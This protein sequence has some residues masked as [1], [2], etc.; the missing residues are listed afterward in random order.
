MEGLLQKKSQ[1][2]WNGLIG[3]TKNSVI[4][5][6]NDFNAS[7]GQTVRFDFSGA[8]VN[9]GFRGKEQAFGKGKDK[10]KFSDSITL[11]YGRYTV[12]NGMKFDA[13][14]IGDIA[15]STHENS[16]GLLADA[17]VRSK[18][19]MFFD[20][21]QGYLRG[22]APTHIIRSA[23]IGSMTAADKI[24]WDYIVDLELKVKTGMGMAGGRRVALE[25]VTTANGQKLW[26]LVLDSWQIADLLLDPKFQAIYQNAQVRGQNNELLSHVIAKIGNIMI[27]EAQ[28]FA[29][30]VENNKLFKQAV[31]TQGLRTIDENGVFSGTG[32]AQSGNVAS[33]GLLLGAGAFLYANGEMPNYLFQPSPDFGI[34]SESCLELTM[35]VEKTNLTAEVEDY[36]DAKIADMDY[37]I[38]AVDTYNE[39]LSA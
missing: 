38:I 2:F 33:R 3:N 14:T 21:G 22:E 9:T 25:P 32:T 10:L 29:G 1:S 18:D 30:W 4:Y 8:Y 24:S 34:T 19:Q 6:K 13:A 7:D 11:E 31:Q 5:Q 37:G 23:D 16:R 12:G 17:Y 27:M 26:L 28:T 20:L 35:N 15:L 39:Q 36:K